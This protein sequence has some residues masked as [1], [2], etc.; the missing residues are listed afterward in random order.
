MLAIFSSLNEPG[1]FMGCLIQSTWL[2][3]IEHVSLIVN[4]IGEGSWGTCIL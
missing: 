4:Y 2:R 3:G 1:V